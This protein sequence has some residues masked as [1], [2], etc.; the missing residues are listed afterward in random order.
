MAPLTPEWSVTTR[1]ARGTAGVARR[2]GRVI[3]PGTVIALVGD[4]GAGKTTFVRALAEGL[5][6][7]DLGAVVSPTYALM[8]VYPG[9][10]CE[11]VHVDLYRLDEPDTARALGIEE[12][13]HRP[14]AVAVVE[15]ADRLPQLFPATAA[16]ITLTSLGGSTRRIDVRG[17]ARPPSGRG[18]P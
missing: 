7:L 6:V 18:R 14:D 15:W 8:N 13:L 16:W 10:R 17:L 11:L 2:L 4:L 9:A 3:A 5:E 1:S 12:Q